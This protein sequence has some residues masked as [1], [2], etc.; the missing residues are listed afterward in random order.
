MGYILDA[1]WVINALAKKRRA[2]EILKE[3]SPAGVCLSIVTLGELYEGPFGTK[4]PQENLASLREF[5]TVFP[6]VA[7]TDSIME[8]FAH[9]R[10][11]LRRAGQLISD[12]DI[13]VGATALEEDLTAMTFNSAHFARIPGLRLYPI[14]G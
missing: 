13:L 3:L 10:F 5:L 11:D 8:R 9:I 1:D 4:H 12:F 2:D 6:V 14:A 7:L